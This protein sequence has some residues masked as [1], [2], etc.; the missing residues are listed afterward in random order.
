MFFSSR[1]KAKRGF[2]GGLVS[3]VFGLEEKKGNKKKEN[4]KGISMRRAQFSFVLF[5]LFYAI[6]YLGVFLLV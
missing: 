4:K 6:C 3:E 1:P 2:K 5:Y